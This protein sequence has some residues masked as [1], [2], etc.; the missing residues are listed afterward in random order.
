[1]LTIDDEGGDGRTRIVAVA[2]EL[3]SSNANELL[4]RIEPLGPELVLDLSALTYMDSTGIAT[5]IRL[6]QSFEGDGRTLLIVVPPDASLRRTLEVR[7]LADPLPLIES[8]DAA[9]ERLAD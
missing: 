2:G 9:R 5:L 1:M 6:W 8:R 4:R 3:D 7:G